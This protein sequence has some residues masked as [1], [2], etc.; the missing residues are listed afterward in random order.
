MKKKG[1]FTLYYFLFFIL[2]FIVAQY[3]LPLFESVWAIIL[4]KLEIPK[5]KYTL[6]VTQLNQKINNLVEDYGPQHAIGFQI[7]NYDDYQE[8]DEE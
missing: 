2:G 6:E 4:T 8:D 7:D 5:G 1:W 3:I